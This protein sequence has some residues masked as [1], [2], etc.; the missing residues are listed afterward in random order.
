VEHP[1][2]EASTR[3]P[4]ALDPWPPFTKS[5]IRHCDWCRKPTAHCSKCDHV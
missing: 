4:S 1:F 2:Y 5:W 3:A